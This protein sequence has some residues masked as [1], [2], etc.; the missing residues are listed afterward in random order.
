MKK[1]ILTD[2][3]TKA[4]LIKTFGCTRQA[5]WQALNFERNSE[6][7]R[8]IRTLALKRGGKLTE[9]YIPDCETSFNES[10]GTMDVTFGERVKIIVHRDTDAVEVVVDGDVKDSYEKLSVFDFT[11]LQHEVEQMAAT[12]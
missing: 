7:A 6:L 9:G 12:I 2:N 3:E 10:E 11:Q 4:F 1:Q 8:K 5:V